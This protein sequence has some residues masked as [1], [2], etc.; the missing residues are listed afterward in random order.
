MNYRVVFAP[1]AEGQLV[2][3]YRFI[4]VAASPVI[5]TR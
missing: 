1:E 3:L 4:A 2:E 5:A